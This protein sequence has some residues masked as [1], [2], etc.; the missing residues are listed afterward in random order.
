MLEV[1]DATMLSDSLVAGGSPW[2][3]LHLGAGAR[4]SLA[5]WRA[6][7]PLE[8]RDGHL[9]RDLVDRGL[10][11]PRWRPDWDRDVVDVI[12]PVR[13][14]AEALGRLLA[15]LGDYS[16]TVV[17]DGSLDEAEVARCAQRY[18][19]RLVRL[20]QNRGPGGAR[21]AGAAVT[22]RPWLWFIDA[23]VVLDD[24]AALGARILSSGADPR[25]A[26]IAP[27]V[28]GAGGSRGRDRFERNHGPLDLGVAGGL[29]VAQTTR[30][31]LPSAC[32]LVRRDAFGDGF[33]E[34]L[35]VGED[36]DL[37]WRLTDAGWLVRYD[38]DLVV[39]H[40]ARAT[41]SSWWRQRYGYGSSAAALAARHRSR[42]APIVVGEPSAWALSGALVG[43]P[44]LV[45]AGV[46]T[47]VRQIRQRLPANVERTRGLVGSLITRATIG[48]GGPI[49]RGLVRTYGPL[50]LAA[51]LARRT[52]RRALL[53]FAL[54]TLWRW[55]DRG[56]F[57]VRDVPLAL[58][59]DLA[60]ALG[61]WRG[62]W[63]SRD[64]TAVTPLIRARSAPR[65][66][67]R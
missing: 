66:A 37:V 12:V 64:A 9:A 18:G 57:D 35:R 25:V 2:R 54:G 20:D 19:A 4:S 6:G 47:L 11:H 24:A 1:R 62:A 39:G 65:T 31:Y 13:E 60:Y 42:L 27:R 52:R 14:N 40:N 23:D 67:R 59:D 63:Q 36:V 43:Q 17:D 44:L 51:A 48:A 56:P 38:A 58:A 8:A 50:V 45:A 30:G 61:V 32:L 16:V 21:N 55:R 29:V 46:L 15:R 41:W 22:T 49:A 28:R 7:A 26:A 53:L 3:L 10:V 33:D 34:A 5:L